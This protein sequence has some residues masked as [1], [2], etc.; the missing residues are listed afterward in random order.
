MQVMTAN[1]MDS[2]DARAF[3]SSCRF[4]RPG[5]TDQLLARYCQA[6]REFSHGHGAN[7]AVWG[8]FIGMPDEQVGGGRW[9]A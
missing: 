2:D 1:V 4:K 8:R 6:G 3:W 9:L 7:E 5:Y